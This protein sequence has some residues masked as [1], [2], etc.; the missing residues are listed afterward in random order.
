MTSQYRCVKVP[1]CGCCPHS[2]INDIGMFC[3][4]HEPYF[5]TKLESWTRD[6]PTWCPLPLHSDFQKCNH[7]DCEE[8]EHLAKSFV[9]AR[10]QEREKV[11]EELNREVETDSWEQEF[12]RHT[13]DCRPDKKMVVLVNDVL[14]KLEELRKCGEQESNDDRDRYDS[15]TGDLINMG[16]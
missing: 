7:G 9:A 11:L 5:A 4:H 14:N 10:K 15:Y 16:R 12:P 8:C 13:G 1:T 3:N 6:T 2:K